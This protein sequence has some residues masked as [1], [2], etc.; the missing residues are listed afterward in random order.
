MPHQTSLVSGTTTKAIRPVYLVASES[1]VRSAWAPGC[2]FRGSAVHR[3]YCRAARR[4]CC[5]RFGT[6][7]RI[8]SAQ[9]VF[10]DRFRQRRRLCFDPFH[11]SFPK[12]NES[13]RINRL[14][15]LSSGRVE[16]V[17]STGPAE[18]NGVTGATTGAQY[19]KSGVVKYLSTLIALYAMRVWVFFGWLCGGK[20]ERSSGTLGII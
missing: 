16:S 15:C 3:R 13:F 5:R 4:P 8:A 20:R 10:I 18:S 1:F 9:I 2:R 14:H 17:N 6:G 11:F 12:T 7:G 19:S